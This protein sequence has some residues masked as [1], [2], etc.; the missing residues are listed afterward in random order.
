MTGHI[1]SH[2]LIWLVIVL[3]PKDGRRNRF[4]RKRLLGTSAPASKTGD[5]LE[6]CLT[7]DVPLEELHSVG[8]AHASSHLWCKVF[9]E[10]DVISIKPVANIENF[11]REMMNEALLRKCIRGL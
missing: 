6:G 2:L 4:R 10:G 7:V 1:S 9:D 8:E 11:G 5:N 3:S